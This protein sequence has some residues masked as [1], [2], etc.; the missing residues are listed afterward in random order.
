MRPLRLPRLLHTVVFALA[1]CPALARAQAGADTLRAPK[2]TPDSA[3]SRRKDD[4]FG[5][6]SDLHL[7]L[8]G[9][10]ESKL[11]K[12]QNDRCVASQY[13]SVAAQCQ[14][15]FQPIFDFKFAVSTGGTVADRLHVNVD[16]DA[17]REFDGSNTISV[18]YE[19]K[20]RDWL[21]RVD[22][23][24]V[25]FEVPSSRFITSGIPQGNYG[26]QA[27]ARFGELRV[28]AIAAQQKGNVVRDRVFTV[29]ARTRL[30]NDRPI[31]DYQVEARRFFFT[32][33]PRR[34]AG[35]P[36]VDILDGPLMRRLA[37][38]LPD[39]MRPVRVTLYRL[40]IGGQPPNPNGPQFRIIGD[41]FSRRGQ[42]YD[43][44]REN[45]D[46]Y[47][48]PSQLWVALARPLNLNNERLVAAYTVRINGRDTTLATTGGTP[49]VEY[50]ATR[51]QFASLLWDPQVR[52]GD[53][54]FSRE[55]R[56][57][58][59]VGGEDVRRETVGVTIVTGGTGEQEKPLGGTARTFLQL[60][61][62]AQLSNPAAFDIDN[63]LW[64][65]PGD[66]VAAIGGTASTRVIRDHYLVFPSL[67]PFARAGLAQPLQNPANDAIY[68]TPGEYLYSVQHPQTVYSIR[69]RYESEGGAG[70]G[71]ALSLPS[72]QVRPGS[73]RL[74]LDDGTPLKRGLDY[75]VDYDVGTVSFLHADT[76]FVRPRAVSVRYEENPQSQLGVVPTSI[77]GLAST[78]PFKY[79]DLNFI[80]IAQQQRSTFTRPQLGYESQ[81]AF[82]AG[83]NGAFSFDAAP[84][85]RLLSRLRGASPNAT[86]RMRIEAEVATSRPQPGGGRPA[87]LET[88]EGD[89]GTTI[90][91]ADPNWYLSSQP[92]LGTKVAARIGSQLPDPFDLARASTLA[93]QSNGFTRGS[94]QGVRFTLSQIDPAT[95]LAGAGV[96]QPEPVLWLTLYPLSIGGALNDQTQRYQWQ[97]PG[98][99]AGRRWRSIR[100]PFGTTGRD[101]STASHLQFFVL[102]DTAAAR[103]DRNPVFV[104][105]LGDI[106]E[107]TVAVGPTQLTVRRSGTT[108]DSAYAGRKLYGRDTLQSERDKFSRAFNQEVNDTGLPG[109]LIPQLAFTSPDSQAILRNFAICSSG[110][111]RLARL[112]DTK[113]NCTVRNGRL[114]EWDLNADNVLNL[115]SSQREQER[116]LR[117]VV[118]L[119]DPKSY[120]RV[121]GCQ[122]SPADPLGALGNKLCWVYVKVPIIAPFETLN[123]GPS[124]RRVQA[125]RLTMISGRGL[126]DDEFSQVPVA[127]FRLTGAPWLVRSN[128][129]LTGVGGDRPAP[130]TVIATSIGTQDK[131]VASGLVYESPPGTLDEADQRQTGLENQRIVINEHSM[132]L[133]ATSLGKYERAEAY[134]RFPEGAR[135]FQQYKEVRA[136]A[137]G[138]GSGWGQGGE[139]QF[140]LKIGR[141]VNNFYL[142]RMPA[143]A[144]QGQAAWLPEVVM[145][146]EKLYALR[147]RLQNA[148]L[149]N[150]PDSISCTG[151]DS[152]LIAQSALPGAQ[153]S[154]R[155]AACADGY[156]VYTVDPAVTPPNLAAV[157]ELAVGMVRVDSAGAGASRIM[158]GDTL[159]LWVDDIR[160]SSVENAP[161]YAAQVGLEL[162]TDLGSVHVRASHRDPHFRQLAETPTNLSNDNVDFSAT[163]RLDRFL[164]PSFG[165]AVPLTLS[166]YTTANTPL[167]VTRS[168]IRGSGIDGLRTPRSDATSVSISLRRTTPLTAGW[169]APLVNN[170]SV[171]GGFNGARSRSEFTVGDNSLLTTGVDYV[172]GGESRPEPMPAWWDRTLVALPRWLSATDL[173]QA[174]RGAQW[175]RQPATFRLSSNYA[176]GD[177]HRSSFFAP[178]L[179][180]ADTGRT[181][182]GFTSFWRNTSALEFRPFDAVSARWELSSLR[183]LRNYGDSTIAASTATGERS[184]VFGLDGGLERERA[185]NTSFSFVPAL[186][187]WLR[188]RAEFTTSYQLQRD[189]NSRQLLRE[190]DSTGAY[191]LPRRVYGSQS[192]NTGAQ[193]NLARVAFR[194]VHDSATQGWLD[195]LLVPI[196]VSYSRALNSAF[197][198]TPFTPGGAYQFGVSG[199]D[200]FLRDHGR[201][202]TN[203]GSNAQL[204]LT[205]GLRLPFGLTFGAR[206]QRVATRNWL[207]RADQSQ[208]VIDGEQTTLPELS[209]RGLWRP[210]ALESVIASI[211]LNAGYA[212]T[213]QRYVVPSATFGGGD[214]R[215]G[216]V[217]R[218]PLGGT[219]QFS[220]KGALAMS[221]NLAST[222]R[223]DSLPGSVSDA[224]ARDISADASR[225]FKLPA[226]WQM[227]SDLRARLGFQQT[228]S[229][230]FVQN[231]FAAGSRSR[232][233]DNG[234]R[235]ISLNADTEIAENLTFSLQSAH[236]VTWD[237]NLDRR[238]T[239]I[240]LSAVLQ[241][242]FFAGELR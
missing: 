138:R 85:A 143:N 157:Q 36:N 167:F 2:A 145:N 81:S 194:W 56:S 117:F 118:D 21:Q 235:A 77:F 136:W 150:R 52:P 66:P 120:S 236:I 14:A 156:M 171:T 112:G 241:I 84:V 172:L 133:L 230:A 119:S 128:R 221:F 57:V 101:L 1:A 162:I 33:D 155:F 220:E 207:R 179:S 229:S 60:F 147:A 226:D 232:L 30:P 89:G 102:I 109:D 10:L 88:F 204:A 53:P 67:Q 215:T 146:F 31:D 17:A 70:E 141:D 163:L 23:G 9:R 78:L 125:L 74:T 80:G 111:V 183:D 132:R 39:T 175:R 99:P 5:P 72:S 238:L 181:V 189:P 188:P 173:V 231:G 198:G 227:R 242:S 65:R 160:L 25:A 34:F 93:W 116:L 182:D 44:L 86:A 82:I 43:V 195:H 223:S 11:D 7:N 55:M 42:I 211:G 97:L 218:Y 151:A 45:V 216:R 113:T 208:A 142:Y 50:V 161:G 100:Q 187:G 212:L 48:D 170:L 159:E 114:D 92:A 193:L 219:I 26:V 61:G 104:I 209:L 201:L 127:Q 18:Y 4:L 63:R 96:Q 73:E 240:V 148:W 13:F 177:D 153:I 178:A 144:G 35:Y 126:G 59:R 180:V 184:R 95:I 228:T 123:G 149:Q 105:D 168:D 108:V 139:L 75:T 217:L 87:Y 15:A 16:Y 197:D 164:S 8:R 115:D 131:D 54:A 137:R 122:P 20:K 29:G 64:P 165:W 76:L 135:S 202:A 158:P 176:K 140:F 191:R 222:Y 174:L 234:R 134:Y 121:G 27:I 22:V 91:L 40:L 62:L 124:L 192:F 239:Q 19:G 154:R 46:Y 32:V 90:S 225:S 186:R 58:Y 237:N 94:P 166:R 199:L 205:A 152:A 49:D 69:V 196:D 24:N 28:R 206:T 12:I 203:A 71:T 233:A 214:L 6:N 79:G 210:R 185:V 213:Q 129:A 47:V 110:N 41:P 106:S 107:N 38:A 37:G 130:G 224:G 169:I 98:A 3:S 83:I 51:E 200:G 103:R 68:V 190:Y